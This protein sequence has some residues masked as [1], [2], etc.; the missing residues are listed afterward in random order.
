MALCLP[1][2]CHLFWTNPPP[3][4]KYDREPNR[5]EQTGHTTGMKGREHIGQDVY[6]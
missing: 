3:P 5:E 2:F 4:Q 6:A 1:T